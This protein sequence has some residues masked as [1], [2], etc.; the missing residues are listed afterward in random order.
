[1]P[2][3]KK[4]RP[5]AGGKFPARSRVR[6]KAGTT[7]PDF[8]DLPLGGWT[9][10]VREID[11]NAHPAS[12]LVEWDRHTLRHIDPAYRSRCEGQGLD[13]GRMWLGE[14]GLKPDTGG[15]ARV[16]RPTTAGPT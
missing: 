7:D 11:R 14:G 16:E 15:S 12:Y 9:G 10:T 3:R 5:P 1:M 6:G 2:G 13:L 4:G 8:P